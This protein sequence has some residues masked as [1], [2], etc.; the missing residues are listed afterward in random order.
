MKTRNHSRVPRT[1]MRRRWMRL[2]VLAW[3]FHAPVIAKMQKAAS[4]DPA[5]TLAA[6]ADGKSEGRRYRETGKASWYGQSFH[7][8]RTASGESFDRHELTGAHRTLPFGTVVKVTNLGNGRSALVRINDRGPFAGNRIIDLSYAAA[9][10]IGMAGRGVAKVRVELV[11]P[12][13]LAENDVKA[14]S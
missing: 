9:R 7:G 13:R 11:A 3:S 4:A 8:R 12:A 10:E 5:M 1:P 6:A 2:G 14:G